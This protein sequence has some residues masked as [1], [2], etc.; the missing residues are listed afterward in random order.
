MAIFRGPAYDAYTQALN[1]AEFAPTT[2]DYNLAAN[3]A[4]GN[5]LQDRGAEI[6]G[7]NPITR[8]LG[9]VATYGAVPFAF[10]ASP[11]HEAAQVVA[12]DKLKDYSLPYSGTVAN[13]TKAMLDQ[14]VPQ[15]MAERAGGVL[16]STNLGKGIFDVAGKTADL[17]R[18]IRQNSPGVRGTSYFDDIDIS[19]PPGTNVGIMGN[20]RNLF[21][22]SAMAN[23]PMVNVDN[24]KSAIN[25][26]RNREEL[27]RIGSLALD[28]AGLTMSPYEEFA[29][30]DKPGFNFNR[31]RNFLTDVKD[32]GLDF[33][34][35]GKDLAL[36]GIGSIIGGPVGGFIGGA[37]GNVKES[38][39]DKFNLQIGRELGDPYGYKSQLTSGTLG[40]RQDPFGR[41]LVSGAGNYEKNRLEEVARLSKLKNL[42][43]FQKAKLDFGKKYL[44]QLETKRQAA[45]QK[46]QDR[47]R[48]A[49]TGGYQAGYGSD[50]ME[51]PS[52]AGYGMG[53][54]DKG[55]S[56]TMGSS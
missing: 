9:E 49:G 42:N 50:F 16:Q 51:G 23:E 19:Q 38:P 2:F 37:L 34:G 28:D 7:D 25:A 46:M 40:S 1:E 18:G 24:V 5:F 52:G 41:N 22:S 32:K 44:E 15:T 35:S 29:Q 33:L 47:N 12:E 48:A 39:T 6:F 8:G 21:S 11:F 13:F 53:A 17:V 54:A 56:D 3:E 43:Q 10:L 55:G 20:L 26:A 30:V 27:N 31:A 14:R 4:A 36:R 45:I